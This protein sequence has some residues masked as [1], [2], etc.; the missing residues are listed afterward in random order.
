M[1]VAFLSSSFPR[2]PG[3]STYEFLLRRAVE[4]GRLAAV[5]AVAPT[6][7]APRVIA[8]RR[9][10]WAAYARTPPRLFLEGVTA[11]YPRYL[12]VPGRPFHELGA[13]CMAVGTLPLLRRLHRVQPFDVLFAQ[14]LFPDGVAAVLLGRWLGV[15]AACLGRGTDVV[16]GAASAARRRLTAWTVHGAAGI[17]VVARDLARV[18]REYV[19]TAAPEVIYNGIDLERFAPAD[20]SGA[21][22]RL[23]LEADRHVALYVGRLAPGKG[24]AVLVD[25][26]AEVRRELPEARLVLLGDGPLRREIAA[27]GTGSGLSDALRLAGEQ[28][29]AE[30]A[31]WINAA[32]VVVLPSESEGFPNV[33]REA[34]ACGRPV[35]ATPVGDVPSIVGPETGALVPVGDAGALARALVRTLTARWSPE[36]LRDTVRDMTWARNA[37][38]TLAFLRR[39]VAV[40]GRGDA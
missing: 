23:G 36:R 4:L 12:Q 26:F 29:H 1:H 32:D 8:R 22:A 24:L 38:E 15:R 18:L 37:A 35:V 39:A 14:A 25:A 11:H 17:A 27:R 10:H 3:A 31:T 20:R 7:W 2:A 33:V 9:E 30:V 40:D 34:L 16:Q 6:P 13:A 21:R 19:P 28:P 5:I